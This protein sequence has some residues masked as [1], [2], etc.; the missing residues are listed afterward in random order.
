[1]HGPHTDEAIKAVRNRFTPHLDGHVL[2]TSRLGHWLVNMAHLPPLSYCHL[3]MLP[4]T[5]RI[6]WPKQAT[7]LATTLIRTQLEEVVRPFGMTLG[8]GD[9]SNG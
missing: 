7:R 9:Q 6:R 1:V 4:A 8:S 2:V 5:S 3:T